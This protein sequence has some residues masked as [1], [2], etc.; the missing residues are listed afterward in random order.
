M[1]ETWCCCSLAPTPLGA[2]EL[3]EVAK[4]TG[5]TIAVTGPASWSSLVDAHRQAARLA[6]TMLRLG[7][8]GESATP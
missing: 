6:A 8:T 2:R 7:R 5:V 3:T 4:R 1:A